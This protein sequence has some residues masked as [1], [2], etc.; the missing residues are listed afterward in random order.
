MDL[1]LELGWPV[2]MLSQ[3]M[4]E[5]EF[6]K[7]SAYS[8]K[9]KLPSMRIELYLA[10]IAYLIANAFGGRGEQKSLADYILD[11]ESR[12]P[13]KA[14]AVDDEDDDVEE[15]KQVLQFKPR[16]KRGP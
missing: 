10:Q 3:A 13:R 4:T 12:D 11:F 16:G 8:H 7:W 6:A 2:S 14:R 9:H 15:L 1:A 5:R